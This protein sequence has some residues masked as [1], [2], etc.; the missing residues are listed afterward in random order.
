[1]KKYFTL[2]NIVF[3]IAIGLLLYKPSRAWIIRQISFSPSVE[4]KVNSKK[5]TNYDWQLKGL[6]TKD[7][8]FSNLKGKVIFVNFW[9]TWCP[10]CI[11]EMPS[12]QE[13]YNEYKDKMAFVF[14]TNEDW[15][16]VDKFYKKHNYNLPT[17][18][19]NNGYLK[20]LP[21]VKSIPRTFVID[22]NGF[23][24]V[25]KTGAADWNSEN[26]KKKMTTFLTEELNSD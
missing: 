5:I 13:F 20:E 19:L 16:V 2:S 24:R 3:V 15:L 17:Y 8:N 7:I 4:K 12:I 1:M 11:A 18:S 25:D 23:I 6:N 14:I 21:S 10:P 9:A 26:F 22:K